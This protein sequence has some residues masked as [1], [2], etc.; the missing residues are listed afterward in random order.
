MKSNIKI[1]IMILFHH[2]NSRLKFYLKL[3]G[4][5]LQRR[6]CQCNQGL[7]YQAC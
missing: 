7:Y 6:T 2:R 4:K 1:I 3:H 5:P